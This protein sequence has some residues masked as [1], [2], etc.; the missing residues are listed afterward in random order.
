M[1]ADIVIA[2][3]LNSDIMG[4]SEIRRNSIN[5]N[6]TLQK[7]V[8]SFLNRNLPR[9]N[10][11]AFKLFDPSEAQRGPNLFEIITTSVYITQGPYHQAATPGG[12]LRIS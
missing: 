8:A 4:K 3:N 6:M 9:A 10:L 12:P 2:V 7:K 5:N 11:R 1:G